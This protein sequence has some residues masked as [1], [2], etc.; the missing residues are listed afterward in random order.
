MVKPKVR[1]K[2]PNEAEVRSIQVVH[3]PVKVKPVVKARVISTSKTTFT[4]RDLPD[5]DFLMNYYFVR[6][7]N[8]ALQPEDIDSATHFERVVY[9]RYGNIIGSTV[10]EL[11]SRIRW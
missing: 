10:G 3:L 4:R 2:D 7:E 9:D 11:N 5:G 8:G 6:D 1:R